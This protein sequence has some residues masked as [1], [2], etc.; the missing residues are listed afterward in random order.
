MGVVPSNVTHS[1][2][3]AGEGREEVSGAGVTLGLENRFFPENFSDISLTIL[4]ETNF[5][6]ATL[7][8]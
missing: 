1:G 3:Q 2:F 7:P 5:Y 6:V 8:L 4:R